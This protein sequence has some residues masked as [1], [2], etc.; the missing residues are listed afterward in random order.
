MARL[1]SI[2]ILCKTLWVSFAAQ[3]F[4]WLKILS[5]FPSLWE[6][7]GSVFTEWKSSNLRMRALEY[8]RLISYFCQ[9]VWVQ[10]PAWLTGFVYTKWS[11]RRRA[12]RTTLAHVYPLCGYRKWNSCFP[13]PSFVTI[14]SVTRK[15]LRYLPVESSAMENQSVVQRFGI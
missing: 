7:Y 12:H 5:D 9:L 4:P 1:E 3:R 2:W 6:D 13:A 14:K 10:H 11:E 8:I 15:T